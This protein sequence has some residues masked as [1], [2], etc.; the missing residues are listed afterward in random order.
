MRPLIATAV[1]VPL[2][3]VLLGV[4]LCGCAD[5]GGLKVTGPASS[6]AVSVAGPVWISERAGQPPVRRPASFEIS[7]SVRLSGLRWK[8][9]GGPTAEA[10]GEVSGGWC[11]PACRD[12]PYPV[13]VT[14]GGLVR[15]GGTGYYSRAVVEAA[16]LPP[17]QQKELRDLRLH[18]PKG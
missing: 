2:T 18:V 11:A 14:L 9:W 10:T 1:A 3:A 8:S 12:R 16:G 4:T 13:G 17:A 7:D 5:P 6:P 15:Q